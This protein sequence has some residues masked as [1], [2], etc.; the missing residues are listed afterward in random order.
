VIAYV[1][2]SVL[3]RLL[4]GQPNSLKAWRSIESAVSSE[5]VRVECLRTIDRTAIRAGLADAQVADLRGSALALMAGLSLAPVTRTI[6]ERAS[7][8]FPTTLGTLDAIHLATAIKA[9]ADVPTL[10]MATHDLELATAARSVGF[11]VDGA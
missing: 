6:L 9:S 3:I 4:F 10:V 8:P 11:Q 2:S 1:D 5:L 7:A